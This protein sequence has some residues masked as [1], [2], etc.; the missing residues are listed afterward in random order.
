MEPSTTEP[1]LS[2]EGRSVA[3]GLELPVPVP[4]RLTV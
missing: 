4:V 3:V 1:K 2:D